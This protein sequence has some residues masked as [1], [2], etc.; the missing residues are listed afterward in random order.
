ML[1]VDEAYLSSSHAFIFALFS[2][3]QGNG[4]SEGRGSAAPRC[5]HEHV[6]F[7]A[8]AGSGH[9]SLRALIALI[10]GETMGSRGCSSEVSLSDWLLLELSRD[11]KVRC[12]MPRF[13]SES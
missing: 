9:P 7:G 11:G 6:V 12:S 8:M 13:N 10:S 5:G 3:V 2:G 4:S 1:K